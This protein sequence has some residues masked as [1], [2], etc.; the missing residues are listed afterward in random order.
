MREMLNTPRQTDIPRIDPISNLENMNR[1]GR[2]HKEELR[3]DGEINT[4]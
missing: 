3:K 2:H 4:G 1:L